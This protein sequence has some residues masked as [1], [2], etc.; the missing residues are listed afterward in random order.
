MQSLK[1]TFEQDTYMQWSIT[2]EILQIK[3]TCSTISYFYLSIFEQ[4]IF[5]EYVWIFMVSKN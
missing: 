4:D 3:F 2:C 1:S 5:L